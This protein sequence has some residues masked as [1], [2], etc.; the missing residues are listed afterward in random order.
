MS[1]LQ[2]LS[3]PPCLLFQ[4]LPGVFCKTHQKHLA[5]ITLSL[6][7]SCFLSVHFPSFCH[8]LLPFFTLAYFLILSFPCLCFPTGRSLRWRAVFVP[9]SPAHQARWALNKATRPH[10][11]PDSKRKKEKKKVKKVTDYLSPR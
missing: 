6:L 9:A 7:S 4:A 8:S 10:F 2:L 1:P 3:M 5:Y 11:Y